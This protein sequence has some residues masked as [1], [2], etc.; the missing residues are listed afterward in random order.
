VI[1]TAFLSAAEW[2]IFAPRNP[3]SGTRWSVPEKV[4]RKFTRLLT[5]SSDQSAM[6]QPDD[7]KLAEVECVVESVSG[8]MA[9]I[10]LSGR[11]EMVHTIEGDK[12][13]LIFGAATAQGVAV[14]D[15]EADSLRSFL[16]VFDGTVRHGR[17]DSPPN[18][19]GAVAQWSSLK[20]G[21]D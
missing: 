15:V 5:A 14:Y 4:A 7:A 12:S 9:Q 17:A 6:P 16:L 20:E 2:R 19:T 3:R 18:R 13:R 11:W 8:G 10:R 21:V 1:D